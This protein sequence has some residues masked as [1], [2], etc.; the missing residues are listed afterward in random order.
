MT[1]IQAEAAM[2]AWKRQIDL[3]LQLAATIVEG[4]EKARD[5]QRDAAVATHAWLQA[6]RSAFAA[7]PPGELGAAQA[8]L[9]NENLGRMAQYW[10]ALATNARDTQARVVEL[11]MR[12]SAGTPLLAESA[13]GT[14][15]AGALNELVDAGYKQ[16]L[17]TLR[18]FYTAPA[19]ATPG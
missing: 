3:A 7:T 17:D 19:A 8:R 5:I 6:A 10:M 2:T 1:P 11:M 18:R 12:S 4:A 14:V 9:A 13:A 16:W 15:P